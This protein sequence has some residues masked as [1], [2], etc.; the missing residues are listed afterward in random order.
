MDG[1][2]EQEE[3]KALLGVDRQKG[4][5]AGRNRC[6]PLAL[7]KSGTFSIAGSMPGNTG[8]LCGWP[9][10]VLSILGGSSSDS[11][12]LGDFSSIKRSTRSH[13]RPLPHPCT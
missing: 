13:W 6:M 11:S 10:G 9:P 7:G 1:W 3:E 2:M 12:L 4:G 5:W 8:I